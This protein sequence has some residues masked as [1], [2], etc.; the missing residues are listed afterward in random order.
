MRGRFT[1]MCSHMHLWV[2][3]P[4]KFVA[5]PPR[6]CRQ[7]ADGH[8]C[9][10]SEKPHRPWTSTTVC[11]RETYALVTFE[12]ALCTQNQGTFAMPTTRSAIC[13][14]AQSSRPYH[15]LFL[16]EASLRCCDR[17]VLHSCTLLCLPLQHVRR[18]PLRN[19]PSRRVLNCRC[20]NLQ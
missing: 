8:A 16:S 2:G 17:D 14:N 11:S 1:R 9:A 10:A 7:R 19:W 6:C 18:R 13:R 5:A 4:Q 3:V 15:H 20:R 12:R